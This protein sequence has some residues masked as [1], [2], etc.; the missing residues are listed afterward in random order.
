MKVIIPDGNS[1]GL[2]FIYRKIFDSHQ[3]YLE[4]CYSSLNTIFNRP[5]EYVKRRTLRCVL[6][7]IHSSEEFLNYT[8]QL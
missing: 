8:Q 5:F 6:W 4:T 7:T 1:G 2:L 3:C